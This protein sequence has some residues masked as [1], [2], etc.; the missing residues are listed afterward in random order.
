MKAFGEGSEW[1]KRQV[2]HMLAQMQISGAADRN[3]TPDPTLF[4]KLIR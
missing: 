1:G 3:E 4:I 2:E